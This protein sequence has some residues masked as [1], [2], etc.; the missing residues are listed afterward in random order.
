MPHIMFVLFLQSMLN[1]FCCPYFIYY[2][3]HTIYILFYLSVSEAIKVVRSLDFDISIS[4][5]S[6]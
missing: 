3:H 6:V 1:N 5:F 2:D 4:T